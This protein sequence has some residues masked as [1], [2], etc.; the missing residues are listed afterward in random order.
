MSL[1]DKLVALL[2]NDFNK[3]FAT[4]FSGSV[5]AQLIPL[6]ASIILARLYS[7]EEF[8][9]LAIFTSIVLIFT[10][11][12]NL[13]YEFAIPL[14]KKDSEAVSIAL[15]SGISAILFSL[16]LLVVF[17]LFKNEILKL[18]E[19]EDLGNWLFLVPLA[20]FF[21]GFYNCLKYFSL[22]FKKYKVIAGSNIIRSASNAGLQLGFGVLGFNQSGL[23]LGNT[24]SFLFGNVR[25][26][27]DFWKYKKLIFNITKRD[28][29]EP[30]IRYK[31]FPLVST[32]GV[33]LNSLSLNINNFF[34]SYFFGMGQLGL[35]S[36]SFRYINAPLSL[37]S[38]NMGQLF[39]QICADRQR[40]NNLAGKEFIST[41]KKL[42]V[43]C[44][45][46]FTLLYFIIQDV[47]VI[48][49]GEKWEMAGYYAQILVPLFF[50]RTIYGPLGKVN[51]A[52]EK[53]YL[54]V[55]MQF[56][57]FVTNLLV[58]TWVYLKGSSMIEFLYLYTFSGMLTYFIL[59]VISYLVAI[60]KL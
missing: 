30:A 58:F 43:V 27:K 3:N 24:L 48:A 33:F 7:P 15:L 13:R 60:R 5:L 22:R 19:G 23:I 25:M 55:V 26:L 36:Y 46:V 45:P 50:V 1:Y 34:I 39:F 9:V 57:I 37:I 16:L 40:D 56:V 54:A 31:K 29:M 44:L 10:S 14:A 49:F 51:I 47:F 59:T 18:I 11:I 42:L 21:N 38:T 52:F 12:V 4:L 20:V 6:V 41:L 17:L 8:G 35:Y 28:L 32:W 2:K 53:Q